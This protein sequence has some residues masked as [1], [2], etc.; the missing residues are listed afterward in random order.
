MASR[1]SSC[2]YL[3]TYGYVFVLEKSDYNNHHYLVCLLAGIFACV[4]GDGYLAW[5]GRG[6]TMPRW[7]LLWLRFQILVV[8]FY[9]GLAKIHLDWLNGNP[10][11]MWLKGCNPALDNHSLATFMGNASLFLDLLMPIA[12][13]WRRSRPLAL[14]LGAIFHLT[15]SRLFS[16]GVFPWMMLAA[17]VLFLEPGTIRGKPV[18]RPRCHSRTPSGPALSALGLYLAIQLLVPL[19]HHLYPGNVDWT[20]EGGCFSWRMRL[21]EHEGRIEFQ[22]EDPDKG[23]HW[24]VYPEDELTAKQAGSVAIWPDLVMQYARHLREVYLR[25]GVR[26]PVV[27]AHMWVSLN[28]WPYQWMMDPQADLGRAR[29]GVLGAN[30]YILPRSAVLPASPWL[31]HQYTACYLFYLLVGLVATSERSGALPLWRATQPVQLVCVGLFAVAEQ[32]G[33][34][35]LAAFTS[36]LGLVAGLQ[37]WARDRDWLP[38]LLSGYQ[39]LWLRLLWVVSHPDF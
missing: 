10:M 29:F 21:L 19:R 4:G 22:V 18:E 17:F 27:R 6:P 36:V 35:Q 26:D 20:E 32:W 3:L 33:W 11:Q 13:I 39:L 8:Y 5:R 30:P 25:K 12:L 23:V 15:N 16:L 7:H 14:A 2:L 31:T 34:L 38:L 28:G 1:S 9:G 37:G 24:V